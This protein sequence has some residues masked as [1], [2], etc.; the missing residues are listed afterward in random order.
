MSGLESID[1]SKQH[2]GVYQAPYSAAVA[3]MRVIEPILNTLM[4]VDPREYTYD[5]KVHMLMPG[6][7]PCIPGWH[8][9]MVPRDSERKQ[10]FSRIQ[11]TRKMFLWLSGPPL[12]QFKDGREVK[13]FT[14]TAFTQLDEHRG[15][16]AE[17][18]C[19]RCFIRAVPVSILRPASPEA[20]RRR[21]SQVYLD[22]EK[23]K[24]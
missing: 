21:H 5:V 9:D 4:V 20:W 13:P 24:W 22:A 18:H 3:I 15:R 10:D 17:E 14:W 1:W 12:T 23:F 8:V 2:C 16:S 7:Y 11:A 6:Q 19:W